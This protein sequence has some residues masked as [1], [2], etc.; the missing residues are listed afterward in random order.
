MSFDNSQKGRRKNKV[1]SL[2]SQRAANE[3][4]DSTIGLMKGK[5]ASVVPSGIEITGGPSFDA[6]N[7]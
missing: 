7:K 2:G 1:S 6:T 4:M 5:N 3:S